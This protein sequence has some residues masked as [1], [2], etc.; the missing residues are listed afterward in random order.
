MLAK[1]PELF[2]GVGG[3]INEGGANET[4]VDRVLFWGIEVQQKVPLWLRVVA[5][6]QAGHGAMPPKDGG[7]AA[8][9]VRALGRLH[10]GPRRARYEVA[11]YRAAHVDGRAEAP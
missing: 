8:K 9:L 10:L 7:A 5:E 1:H 2:A 3:V 11:D 6:G 4:A